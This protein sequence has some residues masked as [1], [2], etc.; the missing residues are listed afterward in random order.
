MSGQEEGETVTT[1]AAASAHPADQATASPDGEWHHVH[2]ATPLVRFWGGLLALAAVI[3]VHL[4]MATVLALWSAL[5][6]GPWWILPAALGVVVLVCAAIWWV[7]GIWWRATGFRVTEEEI[8][9]R[10]G[11]MTKQLR[12]AR[13]ERIQAIDVVEQLVPRI[14]GLAAVRVESAGGSDS[15]MDIYFLK[16]RHAERLRERLLRHLRERRVGEGASISDAATQHAP[17]PAQFGAPE[18]AGQFR[19]LI[20]EIPIQRSL[21]AAFFNVTGISA[22]VVLLIVVVT[23]LPLATVV[24]FAIGFVPA[25]WKVANHAWQFTAKVE[26]AEDMLHISYGLSERR[27]QT[28]PLDRVHAVGMEQ[29][30]L[31]R[32]T[33]WWRV[34]VSVA[35]Y[36][37]LLDDSAGSTTTVLPVGSRD[38]AVAVFAEA[39]GM[40]VEEIERIATPEGAVHP[41]LTSP[42]AAR[43]VSPIDYTKQ[44]VTITE[45]RVVTHQRRVGHAVAA[46]APEHIQEVSLS[47]GPLQ[48]AMGL[49]T[50][51]L[52]LVPGPVA[53]RGRDLDS[54]D[55]EKLVDLLRGRRLPELAA[56]PLS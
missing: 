23:P 31:W 36:G 28:V 22:V 56:T 24:P 47:S 53:M 15:H 29:S 16:K 50:V 51:V 30:P 37:G 33:G 55:A 20:P 32:L 12:T 6:G 11:V 13:F 8:A 19:E 52:H 43:W 17:D 34:T 9:V 40:S 49:A 7:S 3:V 2:R 18:C 39:S 45:G 4:N 42:H 21:G 10:R 26:D 14:F 41:T 1:P 5:I 35:G 48:R 25:I 54:K 27:R 38:L 46:I 44:A